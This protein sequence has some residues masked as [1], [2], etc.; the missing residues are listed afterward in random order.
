[1]G[2]PQVGDM[3]GWTIEGSKLSSPS[4]PRDHGPRPKGADPFYL[5]R[6]Q[7]LKGLW[8]R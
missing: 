3:S 5:D 6:T 2:S 7:R 4:R 8:Q 1:M